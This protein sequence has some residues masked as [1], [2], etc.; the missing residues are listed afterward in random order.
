[1]LGVGSYAL[2]RKRPVCPEYS[3]VRLFFV[4][5]PSDLFVREL[6]DLGGG[7]TEGTSCPGRKIRLLEEAEI[8]LET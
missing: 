7:S 5:V 3:A 4:D 8:G 2:R 1:M 6:L